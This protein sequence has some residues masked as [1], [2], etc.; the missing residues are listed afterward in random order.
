MSIVLQVYGHKP[1]Q[2]NKL[3]KLK[4]DLMMALDKGL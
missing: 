4:C 3:D 2:T 1:K